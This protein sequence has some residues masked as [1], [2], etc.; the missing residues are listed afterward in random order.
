MSLSVFSKALTQ[1]IC[2]RAMLYMKQCSESDILQISYIRMSEVPANKNSTR[3][4]HKEGKKKL[5]TCLI[6][7]VLYPYLVVK[8][9]R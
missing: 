2:N 7:S 5:K 8:Y 1:C 4:T 3:N 9:L 6:E